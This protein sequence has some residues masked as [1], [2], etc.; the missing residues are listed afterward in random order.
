MGIETL[1]WKEADFE[2][3][4][5]ASLP[6][7][8]SAAGYTAAQLKER[9]DR[10]GKTMLALGSWNRLIDA[11]SAAEKNASGAGEIGVSAIEGLAGDDVQTVLQS[12]KD[13]MDRQALEAGSVTSV[14]EKAGDVALE[15]GDLSP[16]AVVVTL[17][18]EGWTQTE[19]GYAQTASL[20]KVRP[21]SCV[22]VSPAPAGLSLWGKAQICCT[23]QEAGLLHFFAKK[24]PDGDAAANVLIVG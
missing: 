3:N 13:Y 4:D 14:C 17:S 9:F 1:K 21:Q 18:A 10:I 23:A 16:T 11:L 24:L 22:I 15:T 19:S 2:N 5:V 8:P 7:D 20:A 12:L 6:D